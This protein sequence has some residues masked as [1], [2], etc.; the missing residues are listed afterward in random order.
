MANYWASFAAVRIVDSLSFKFEYPDDLDEYYNDE[1]S[2]F[3]PLPDAVFCCWS[4]TT[5]K[6]DHCALFD[7]PPEF[8]RPIFPFLKTV[9][10]RSLAFIDDTLLGLIS[11]SPKI[12]K[13]N[14]A[15]SRLTN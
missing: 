4:I 14:I 3:I 2:W 8:G 15:G 9:F 12:K 13:L 5:L 1:L 11:S 7:I 6:L 10:L